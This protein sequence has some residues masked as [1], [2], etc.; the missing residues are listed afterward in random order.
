MHR[1]IITAFWILVL[2]TTAPAAAEDPLLTLTR[3]FAPDPQAAKADDEPPFFECGVELTALVSEN[4]HRMSPALRSNIP[5]RYRP[6]TFR[7]PDRGADELD[8]ICD[9]FLDSEHFRVHYSTQ[10]EHQPPGY[11]DLQTVRDLA[12]HLETAYAY[13]RD[14]SGMGVALT[15]GDAGGGVDLIDC[16]FLLL[17]EVWGYAERLAAAPGYC[18]DAI[19][20][21]MAVST[22]FDAYDFGEQLRLTSEH[23]YFHLLQYAYGARNSWFMES[24]ARNSEFH[25]WPAIANPRGALAWMSAPYRPVW[26]ATG[27]HRY[28]PHFWMYLEVNHGRDVVTRTWQSSC[29]RWVVDVIADRMTERG[30]DLAAVLTDFA[31]WNYFTGWRDDGRHYDPAFNLPAVYYQG[32]VTAYPLPAARLPAAAIA[33]PAGS[34]YLRFEGPASRN[35]L[36]LTVDGHPDLAGRRAVVV[37]GVD[38]RGH[39]AWILEPD[40]DGDVDFVVP[41]WGIYDHVALVVTNFREAPDDSVLLT[42]TFAAEEVALGAAASSLARV[43]TAAPN[44]F[45]GSTRIVCFAPRDGEISSVRIYDTAGRLVRTL[46]DTPV[47]AG[48]HELV[49]DGTDSGGRRV[50]TGMYLVRL[51][52]GTQEHARK[53]MF[54]R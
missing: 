46:L 16:Y 27:F 12:S 50:A 2:G 31:I 53:V 20:G 42:Y 9:R 23:E 49:W 3:L 24:T 15:D 38:A 34:N 29:D 11:P 41:D 19:W 8:D 25:V 35:N 48:R 51:R 39:R 30:T 45:V 43:V 13:H 36:R 4:W 44:P 37:L 28:A 17:E 10:P 32:K 6:E 14:V 33:R 18:A 5:Q 54:V 26:D 22:D 7:D 52:N 21:R 47:Y 1:W 40:A